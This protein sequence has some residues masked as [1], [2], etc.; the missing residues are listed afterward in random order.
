MTSRTSMLAIDGRFVFERPLRGSS[1]IEGLGTT[2]TYFLRIGLDGVELSRTSLGDSDATGAKHDGFQA[3]RKNSKH[4]RVTE[5]PSEQQ[6][7]FVES[8]A[9]ELTEPQ[10]A[11]PFAIDTSCSNINMSSVGLSI[12][13]D[14]TTTL[15]FPEIDT[16]SPNASS[17]KPFRAQP[18][19]SKS[20]RDLLSSSGLHVRLASSTTT[21]PPGIANPV[22][23]PR[24]ALAAALG[25]V[26][27]SHAIITSPVGVHLGRDCGS[28]ARVIIW[29]QKLPNASVF[30]GIVHIMGSAIQLLLQNNSNCVPGIPRPLYFDLEKKRYNVLVL[31]ALGPSLFSVLKYCGGN[32][33]AR[34]VITLGIQLL[35]LI[36]YCHSRQVLIND[37]SPHS[38]R[39]GAT[40]VDSHL[41][42][43]TS[44][45]HCVHMMGGGKNQPATA[46]HRV[47]GY[48]AA[49]TAAG[50]N[51][52]SSDDGLNIS[53]RSSGDDAMSFGNRS[54]SNSQFSTLGAAL[55]AQVVR[56]NNLYF[57]SSKYHLGLPLTPRDDIESLA[58][59]MAY[60]FVGHLPWQH[61]VSEETQKFTVVDEREAEGGSEAEIEMSTTLVHHKSTHAA[62]PVAPNESSTQPGVPLA[63]Q[64]YKMK[65]QFVIHAQSTLNL[66][67]P[68]YNVIAALQ[69]IGKRKKVSA[70]P[71]TNMR[72][73]GM[74]GSS[75]LQNSFHNHSQ[76]P[77][78]DD[79]CF[80]QDDNFEVEKLKQQMKKYMT[81]KWG[82]TEGTFEWNGGGIEL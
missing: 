77:S 47:P 42:Y 66:P 64:L 22:S 8:P 16:E 28:N 17:R 13:T 55:D 46:Q 23:A 61:L 9:C 21:G 2:R 53:D 58:F 18:T 41:L 32:L 14:N 63:R 39:F 44:F 56:T 70:A 27:Q 80:T 57:C 1:D 45:A 26:V 67:E 72:V 6:V 71:T 33:S 35:E 68:V 36:Q 25:A 60:C 75:N 73:A 74:S 34:T 81:S 69:R 76:L 5:R 3:A 20:G 65:E 12:P 59:I 43:I 78:V 11:P 19:L 24:L 30:R 52:D 82:N 49:K 37:L 10:R 31:P 48:G 54:S 79:V 7:T 50:T 62:T 15:S 4:E 29:I 51:T 38:L 40:S